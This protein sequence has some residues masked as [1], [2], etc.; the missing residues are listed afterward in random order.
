MKFGAIRAVS[1]FAFVLAACGGITSLGSGSGSDGIHA[2]DKNGGNQASGP[3]AGKPC[4]A[5]CNNCRPGEPCPEIAQFCGPDGRCDQAFPA[6]E[7]TS[8]ETHSDC[9]KPEGPCQLCADGSHACP[10]AS[11]IG[12]QCVASFDSCPGIACQ[13][14]AECPVSNAP[15]QPCSDGTFACPVSTCEGGHCAAQVPGC[16]GYSPCAGK[17]CGEPCTQCAP[18]DADCFETAV[19]KTCD[20]NGACTPGQAQC[21]GQCRIDSDCPAMELCKLCPGGDCANM[22]CRGGTCGWECPKNSEPECRT[23]KDCS[24]HILICQECGN[25]KCAEMDCVS[26]ECRFVCK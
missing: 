14:D 2:D 26:G 9:I 21:G 12:G 17:A 1:V 16:S 15:C 11:C 13:S 10:S 6:C 24:P 4:G 25:G 7:T 23:V 19:L 18:G 3:C 8:C 22:T 20:A 5:L